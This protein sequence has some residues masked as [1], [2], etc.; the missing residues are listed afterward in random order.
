MRQSKVILSLI[1]LPRKEIKISMVE[2]A[3][4]NITTIV[5][6]YGNRLLGFIRG[7]VKSEEDAE[8]ILQEVWYQ[9]SGVADLNGLESASGWLYQVARN[10]I[11]DFYRKRKTVSLDDFSYENEEGEW[12]YGDLM[13][14]D[15]D[16]QPELA[17]MKEVFWEELMTALEELPEN[18]RTV[19]IKNELD[20]MTLQEIAEQSGE[21]LKTI[22]SRKGYA[23]KHLR[24]RLSGLYQEL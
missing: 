9:L 2:Q 8:D 17:L 22:I 6:D 12:S 1:R 24:K 15:G 7:K 10:R 23:V 16:A 14:M 19:F 3:P 21:N 11:T 20:D 5:K 13:L 18:Q 4:R